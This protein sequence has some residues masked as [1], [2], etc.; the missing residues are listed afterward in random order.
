VV[1]IVPTDDGVIATLEVPL[2]DTG[3]VEEKTVRLVN[4]KE[5]G[6]RIDQEVR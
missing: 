6:W 1:K 3:K 2:G 5:K 4:V